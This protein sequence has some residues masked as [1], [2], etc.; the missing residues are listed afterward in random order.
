MWFGL[1][2][3]APGEAVRP[4]DLSCLSFA[5]ALLTAGWVLPG[6]LRAFRDQQ[7]IY[8][9]S[10]VVLSLTPLPFSMVSFNLIGTLLNL[11]MK[12]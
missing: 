5:V 1:F 6:A 3:H 11:T 10:I 4:M 9:W 12:P 7:R 8:G 2:R